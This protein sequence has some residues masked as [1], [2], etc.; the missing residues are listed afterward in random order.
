MNTVWYGCKDG[1]NV[2][3]AHNKDS[4]TNDGITDPQS[5]TVNGDVSGLS[6]IDGLGDQQT[7]APT[8]QQSAA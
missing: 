8:G 6:F 3:F 7:T 2:R 5:F 4:L 1:N